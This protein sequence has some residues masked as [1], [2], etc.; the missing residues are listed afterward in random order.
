MMLVQFK[1]PPNACRQTLTKSCLAVGSPMGQRE[2]DICAGVRSVKIFW[3]ETSIGQP[4]CRQ[5]A[6]LN[7]NTKEIRGL[8]ENMKVSRDDVLKAG[9][10]I[11]GDVERT[12]LIRSDIAGTRVWLK[13]ECL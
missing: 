13:C 8:T 5:T 4:I 9:E 11:A 10:R 1:G 7:R 3:P 2:R 6:T 12:P